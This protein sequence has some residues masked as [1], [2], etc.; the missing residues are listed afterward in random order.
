[1][2]RHSISNDCKS[3]FLCRNECLFPVFIN[4]YITPFYSTSTTDLMYYKS[5]FELLNLLS[6]QLNININN[7]SIHNGSEC[8]IKSL[9]EVLIKESNNWVINNPTFEMIDF[10]LNYY[11]S[12]IEKLDVNFI[13]NKFSFTTEHIK[14]TKEK[15][16]FLV[17]PHNPTGLILNDDYIIKLCKK[18]KYVIIDQA[19]LNP[20]SPIISIPNLILIRSFS[21][22][23]CITGQ[24]FGFVYS[25]NESIIDDIN[26][27]RPM[28]LPSPTVKILEYILKNNITHKF[29]KYL[30]SIIYKRF[31]KYFQ[32]DILTIAG[33]F[34]LL[35]DKSEYK[36][37][38]VKEYTFNDLKCY[39]ITL[40]DL[41]VL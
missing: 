15:I 27:I 34:I 23:G 22:M 2:K 18:F 16:I 31:K 26:Q 38:K 20:M 13:N 17:S 39:R 29:D 9:I 6:H 33:N 8:A 3:H 40:H 10:Y 19:Y 24:R 28:F 35:K 25:S 5:P 36:N 4:K 41:T 30:K 7:I 21:K 12:N 1:M 11:N 14:Q 32:D 37:Y